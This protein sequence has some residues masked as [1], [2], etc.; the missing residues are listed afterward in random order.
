MPETGTVEL[1]CGACGTVKPAR[2]TRGGNP[3]LPKGWKA[4]PDPEHEDPPVYTCAA[5]WKRL[6]HLRAVTFPVAEV[7]EGGTWQEFCTAVRACLDRSRALAQWAVN[8]LAQT[9]VVRTN[10]QAT[11]PPHPPIYLYGEAS[12]VNGFH[13]WGEWTGAMTAANAVLHA[14]EQKYA[15]RRLEVVWRAEASLPT[16]RSQPYPVPAQSY[17]AAWTEY[18][19]TDGKTSRVPS[20]SI[21]LD[22]RRWVLRLRGGRQRAR[23]LVAFAHIVSGAAEKGE[24]AVYRKR[25][26]SNRD[27]SGMNGRTAPGGGAR[28]RHDVMVKLVAWLSRECRERVRAGALTVHSSK[29]AFLVAVHPDFERPWVLRSNQVRRWIV[30]HERR[31]QQISE[32]AKAEVR[33]QRPVPGPWQRLT[34]E[35]RACRRRHKRMR[36]HR[37][38]HLETISRRY[39]QQLNTY[40]QTAAAWL[41][42]YADR[43]GVSRV[44]L[45]LSERSYCSGFPWAA[46]RERIRANLEDRGIALE[47]IE[48][49]VAEAVEPEEAPADNESSE[50]SEG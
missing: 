16:I 22:G 34:P 27:R 38:D 14:V 12:G 42:A 2:V 13:G 6:Y 9:D 18:E 23:Q 48:D 37:L 29:N 19:G 44:C 45:D 47:L 8:R 11:M 26:Q 7:L 24:L 31:I 20:V 49:T 21:P 43:L 25:T 40:V 46:L 32:D 30:Q 39:H 10:D 4:R 17:R 1:R 50:T 36:R 35:Q 28:V 3:R 15:R 33:P 5:C 41:A